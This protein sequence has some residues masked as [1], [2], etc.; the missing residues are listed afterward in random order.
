[1]TEI[2]RHATDSLGPLDILVNNAG[3][4]ASGRPVANCDLEEVE[5]LLKVNLIGPVALCRAVIPSMRGRGG[6]IVMI[7]S[8]VVRDW[9]AGG[10][11]YSIAKAALEALAHT[12]VSEKTRHG[13]RVN[14]VRPGMVGTRLTT[15]VL[16]RLARFPPEVLSDPSLRLFTAPVLDPEDIANAVAFL[17]SDRASHLNG[18]TLE[19][20]G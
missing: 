20:A 9:P 4:G 7:S 17:V 15:E 19:I 14:I 5:R 6:R 8:L 10:G 2:V 12:I 1:M 13:I 3:V 16:D 11:P 18:Q